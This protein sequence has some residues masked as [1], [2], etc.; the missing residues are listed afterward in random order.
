ML[1]GL[2]KGE[3]P[4]HN[5]RL[6]P[7]VGIESDNPVSVHL[8]SLFPLVDKITVRAS[9]NHT[10]FLLSQP[11]HEVRYLLGITLPYR[12]PAGVSERVDFTIEFSLGADSS[13]FPL[14][15]TSPTWRN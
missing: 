10:D 3:S 5:S 12:I 11:S 14:L 15:S 8:P 6:L 9:R 2:L 4:C 13:H 7:Q 1:S